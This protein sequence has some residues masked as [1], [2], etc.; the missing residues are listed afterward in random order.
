MAKTFLIATHN[1]KKKNELLRI[2]APLG[3]DVKTDSELGL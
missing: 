1:Q 2:L 3:I